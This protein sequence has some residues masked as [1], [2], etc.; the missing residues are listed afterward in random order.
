MD[1]GKSSGKVQA[2]GAQIAGARE[3]LRMTQDDLAKAAGVNRGTIVGFESGLRTPYESSREKI[4]AALE[5]RGIVFTNGNK[6]GFH[7]DKEKATVQP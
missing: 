3:F 7:L 5:T 2:T 4:Q 1:N 6:P